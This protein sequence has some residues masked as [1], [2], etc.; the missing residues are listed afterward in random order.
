MSPG[1]DSGVANNQAGVE[2]SVLTSHRLE[3]S[4]MSEAHIASRMRAR[5]SPLLTLESGQFDLR[6]YTSQRGAAKSLHCELTSRRNTSS[7]G[8]PNDH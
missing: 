5:H 8:T 1:R 7:R 6:I 2:T 4:R 3:L